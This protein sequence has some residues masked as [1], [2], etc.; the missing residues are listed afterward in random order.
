MESEKICIGD[1]VIHKLSRVQ[2]HDFSQEN[3]YSP[4]PG[5]VLDFECGKF[6]ILWEAYTEWVCDAYL[7][8][9]SKG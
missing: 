3:R 9:I 7:L 5:I 4:V 2:L 8:K 6:L 1:L